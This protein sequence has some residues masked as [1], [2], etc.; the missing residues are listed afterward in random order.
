MTLKD[1]GSANWHSKD[2]DVMVELYG[3]TLSSGALAGVLDPFTWDGRTESLR[4][5]LERMLGPV[6]VRSESTTAAG[7]RRLIEL[8]ISTLRGRTK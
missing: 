3:S 6:R 1:T 7:S 4:A 8:E 5:Y 2:H